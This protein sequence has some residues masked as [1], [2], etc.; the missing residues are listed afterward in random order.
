LF[1]FI[2]SFMRY[3][4]AF[5]ALGDERG[6]KHYNDLGKKTDERD[7]ELA[8]TGDMAKLEAGPTASTARMPA[9]TGFCI[10]SKLTRP[11]SMSTRSQG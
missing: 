2:R 5:H 4:L 10:N 3:L 6:D 9:M 8:C 1:L 7:I 11:E